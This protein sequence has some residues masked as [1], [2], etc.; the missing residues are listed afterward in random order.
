MLASEGG[1]VFCPFPLP[2]PGMERGILLILERKSV[3]DSMKRFPR[4]I[5][6]AIPARKWKIRLLPESKSAILFAPIRYGMLR[7]FLGS[8]SRLAEA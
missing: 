5:R 4:R 8:I 1:G 7:G 2:V 6:H 3:P